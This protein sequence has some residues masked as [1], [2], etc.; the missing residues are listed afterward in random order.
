M[1]S[2]SRKIILLPESMISIIIAVASLIIADHSNDGFLND[3]AE[4]RRARSIS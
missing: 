1:I 3:S 4:R 2:P